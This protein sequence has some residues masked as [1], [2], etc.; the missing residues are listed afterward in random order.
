MDTASNKDTEWNMDIADLGI[1][2][3]TDTADL[4]TADHFQGHPLLDN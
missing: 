2:S 1:D 4:D 3:S